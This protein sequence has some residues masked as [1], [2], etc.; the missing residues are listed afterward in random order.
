MAR[1][2]YFI[3][4]PHTKEECLAALDSVS[5]KGPDYL[6]QWYFGC[7]TGDHTGYAFIQAENEGEAR[8]YIPDNVRNKAR[9]VKVDQYNQQQIRQFH[10]SQPAQTRNR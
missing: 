6:K 8:N 3:T 5:E 1:S 10:E 4:S 9:L 2:T 7:Q